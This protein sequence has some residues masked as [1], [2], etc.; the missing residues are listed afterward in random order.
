MNRAALT[1]ALAVPALSPAAE[2]AVPALWSTAATR[3]LHKRACRHHFSISAYEQWVRGHAHASRI[4][5]RFKRRMWTLERC[6]AHGAP[7]RLAAIRWRIRFLRGQA[8]DQTHPFSTAL[9]SWYVAAGGPIAC[10]D[11]SYA[12]GVASRTL[13]CGAQL[14]VCYARCATVV[15]FDRGSAAWTGRE[16]DLS[17]AARDAT[18]F[19]NG[20]GEVRWRLLP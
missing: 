16:F 19:P 3:Q 6:Q 20:V 1:L 10:G 7:A 5:Q 4:P 17:A 11:D 18:G 12:V 9:A 14:E 8:W 2:S 13:P 15:V